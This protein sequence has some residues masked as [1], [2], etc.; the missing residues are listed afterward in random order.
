MLPTSNVFFC[1]DDLAETATS[2][3]RAEWSFRS[4]RS[5]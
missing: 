5:S 1:C 4:R 3:A 2:F